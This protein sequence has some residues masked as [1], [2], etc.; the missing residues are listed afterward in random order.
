MTKMSR[1][2]LKHLEN[3]TS[4][5]GETKKHFSSFLKAFIGKNFLRP[6]GALLAKFY[7]R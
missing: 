4:F 3:E 1:Q 2:R 7:L 5:E 6:V